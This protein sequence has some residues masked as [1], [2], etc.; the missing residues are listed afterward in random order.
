MSDNIKY[1]KIA[2]KYAVPIQKRQLYKKK[3]KK[4]GRY[5]LPNIV[6]WK[7]HSY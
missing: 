7:V 3:K 2:N 1:T 6:V 4:S 5:L